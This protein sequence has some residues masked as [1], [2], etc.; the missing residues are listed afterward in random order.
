MSK[1]KIAETVYVRAEIR[2]VRAG[3]EYQGQISFDG[4]GYNFHLTSGQTLDR[5]KAI[6]DTDPAAAFREVRIKLS[7]A[8]GQPVQLT[9]EARAEIMA[10]TLIL[11]VN[12]YGEQTGPGK[13]QIEEI[14]RKAS[15]EGKFPGLSGGLSDMAATSHYEIPRIRALD[16]ILGPSEQP[17]TGFLSRALDYARRAVR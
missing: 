11:A 6:S 4:R 2:P 8:R 13:A 15:A 10:H 16:G 17:R 12:Y 1:T 14:L 3:Y 5:V 7:D 9:D